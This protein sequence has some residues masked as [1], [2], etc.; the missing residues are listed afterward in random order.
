MKFNL[1]SLTCIQ[2]DE[3]LHHGQSEE[4]GGKVEQDVEACPG[5]DDL[6]SIFPPV[7]V[8]GEVVGPHELDLVL[9]GVD[10]HLETNYNRL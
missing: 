9:A 6:A 7:T 1:S 4:G 2:V 3:E 10:L 8:A 5:E